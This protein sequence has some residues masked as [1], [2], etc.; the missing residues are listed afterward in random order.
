METRREARFYVCLILGFSLLVYGIITPPPG[1]IHQTT[2]I[3]AGILFAIGALCVGIDI[4]GIIKD[5]VVLR[6]ADKE[7]LTAANNNKKEG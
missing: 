7:L 2:I 4:R 1:E 5:L 3:A 6:Q